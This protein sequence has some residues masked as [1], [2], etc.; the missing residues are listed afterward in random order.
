MIRSL[1]WRSLVRNGN[2]TAGLIFVAGVVL[3]AV[4]AGAIAPYPPTMMNLESTFAGPEFGHILGSDEFGRDVLSRVIDGARASLAIGVSAV[5]IGM[6]LGGLPALFAGY[7]G[8]VVD[9]IFTRIVDIFMA[10]PAL[11]VALGILALV[12]PSGPTVALAIAIAYAPTFAR[13]I[14]SAVSSARVQAYVEASVGMGAST[15]RV[16]MTEILPNVLPIVIVQA[17]SAIAW[18]IL[19]EANLGFLGVGVQ[20]PNASW[21]SL[22][23]EG[24]Q[25]FFQAPWLPIGAGLAVLIAVL[26]FNLL[27][28]ALRDVLDPRAWQREI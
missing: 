7:L 10:I 11:L 18:A 24:R 15:F 2:G 20:P 1:D 25:Y 4:L 22:L 23:I 27:G 13:V 26:G 16:L 19:D 17:T 8:G 6:V 14:R 3:T 5:V 28:D 21:G 12:G 9:L